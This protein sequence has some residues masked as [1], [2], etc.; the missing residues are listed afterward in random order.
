MNTAV[1]VR[2]PVILVL[3][4]SYLPG[5]RGGGPVRSISN[6][7]EALGDELE[8]RIVTCDRDIGQ[9]DAYPEIEPYRWTA[10]GKGRVMYIP[11]GARSLW[12]FMAVL[13]STPADLLY[14]NSLF[15]RKYSMLPSLLRRLGLLHSNSLI[16]AP[17]G[18]FSTGALQ[19]KA[20][21][22]WGY[23]SV[24][25][26][27]GL[28]RQIVWH[29]SSRYEEQDIRRAFRDSESI[30]IARPLAESEPATKRALR[31]VTAPD[32]PEARTPETIRTALPRGK[33]AGSLR[34]VFLSR[35]SRMKNLEGALSLLNGLSGQVYFTI[36]GP[37]EDPVYWQTCQAMIA[38]LPSNVHV[39][40]A[41][42]VSHDAV[43]DVLSQSDLFLFPT[44]GE[45]YGHVILEALLAG[46][47]IVISDQTPWRNL[48]ELGVGWDLPLRDPKKF[49]EVLQTCVDMGPEAFSELSRRAT[50]FGIEKRTDV[51]LLEQNRSLF[52]NLLPDYSN[53]PLAIQ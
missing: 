40:Y 23:I 43:Q 16:L 29:A 5:Y 10:V 52:F 18:E 49:Q 13:R 28:Y 6:A 25:R 34:L 38:R 8:F 19:L 27:V 26:A 17:R 12:R 1:T 50:E 47:P 46:C 24:S 21:R 51:G 3:V 20:W 41:G 33:P 31:I 15:A 14:L 22:K 48:E 53:N 30:T 36:Y 11:S 32:L 7:V 45:N 42:A 35:I 9:P 37:V 2:K 4:G 39:E 44:L